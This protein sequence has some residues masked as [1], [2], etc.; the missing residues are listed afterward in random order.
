[1]VSALS[2][3]SGLDGAGWAEHEFGDCELGDER[4]TRRLVKIVSD[5][6]AQPS[7]SYS[8]AAGGNRHDLKGYYRFL[9]NPSPHLDGDT[10][11]I[12]PKVSNARPV[13]ELNLA[14]LSVPSLLPAM[15][16]TPA[17][18]VTTP[19]RKTLRIVLFHVS[20]T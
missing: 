12:L 10:L 11:Y 13:G 6:A 4:L 7:G 16:A 19:V 18:V 1:M 9:N 20:A 14:S 15:L 3:E 17:T 5:Q 8:Q 2:P